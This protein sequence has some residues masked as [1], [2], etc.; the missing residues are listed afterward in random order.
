MKR[1]T[2]T[3]RMCMASRTNPIPY[4][5]RVKLPIF[6]IL[7]SIVT[8]PTTKGSRRIT[9]IRITL[10]AI[11]RQPL[12]REVAMIGRATSVVQV[13]R[14]PRRVPPRV[15]PLCPRLVSRPHHRHLVEAMPLIKC[16]V[17]VLTICQFEA[18]PMLISEPFVEP[19]FPRPWSCPR[20]WRKAASRSHTVRNFRTWPFRT[21]PIYGFKP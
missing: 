17:A 21:G 18:R 19:S 6:S 7:D 11:S 9:T 4:F 1:M 12:H 20:S 8:I 10:T 3:T 15:R 2:T 5:M 14:Q 16:C 13:R